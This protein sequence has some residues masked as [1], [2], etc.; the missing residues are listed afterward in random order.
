M[1]AHFTDI[2]ALVVGGRIATLRHFGSAGVS[3]SI[4]RAGSTLDLK[5][6]GGSRRWR[7]RIPRRRRLTRPSNFAYIE[8]RARR[9]QAGMPALPDKPNAIPPTYS[10]KLTCPAPDPYS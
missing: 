10:P 8:K 5:I 3:A 9:M 2:R 6:A 7:D 1:A 4:R